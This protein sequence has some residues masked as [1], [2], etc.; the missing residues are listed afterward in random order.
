MKKNIMMRISAA[1]L[2][3]VLLTTCVISGTFAKYVTSDSAVDEATVA[4][5][6]VSVTVLGDDAFGEKYNDEIHAEGTKVVSNLAGKNVLAPGTNGNLGGVTISGTPEVRVSVAVDLTVTLT[7]WEIIVEDKNS[8]DVLNDDDK[9]FYCPLVVS[10]G[11]TTLKGTEYNTAAAFIAAIEALVDS[12]AAEVA[13]NTSLAST[14]DV[15][16]TW[17][18]A[19]TGD[20]VRDTALGNLAT[21]PTI[22]TSWSASVTQVD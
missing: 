7:G 4:K 5:W 20:D 13:A 18:W 15:A 6:G 2:V 22:E 1:L 21:L 19:F 3:A 14:Y 16:L 12:A 9:E 17:S 11:T 8:D 10:D